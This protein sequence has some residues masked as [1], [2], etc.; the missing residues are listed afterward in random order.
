[1]SQPN[2]EFELKLSLSE[3][4]LD[5]VAGSAG[6]ANDGE[7]SQKVLRSVYYDSPDHRLHDNGIALR[8]RD[9]GRDYL[10]TV[11]AD[12]NPK[13]GILN[14]IEIEDRIENAEPKLHLI[15]NKRIR[16]K[17]RKA[18]ANS[19]LMPA[20]ETIV[21]R[22]TH[23]LS[24]RGSI[25]ELALDK[26]EAQAAGRKT[27]ICEAE[28]ELIAGDP[29]DL[30]EIAQSLFSKRAIHVSSIS[31]AERGYRLLLK[32]RKQGKIE[33]ARGGK[34]NVKAGQTCGKAFAEIFRSAREQ[35]IK[36][37]LVV[38]ETDEPEGAHQLRVGL[39]RLRSAHRVLRALTD[40]PLLQQLEHD[41]QALSRAVGRLRDADVLIQDIYAP[42]AGKNAPKR[43]GFN[44]LYL[45]L[46]G[47]RA[48][49]QEEARRALMSEHWS[50]LL[51]SLTLW[52][53]IL[54]RDEALNAPIEDYA[55]KALQNRWKKVAKLGRSL[56]SLSQ[57]D[58]H[59][60]RR[61][62]KKLRYMVEFFSPLYPKDEVRKFV[63]KLKNLQDIFGYMNDVRMGGQIRDIC[64]ERCG[65]EMDCF[66]AA[67]YV[68]GQHELKV[69]DV[70]AG[71]FERWRD[72]EA[73]ER[74]WA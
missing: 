16:R 51:L 5:C 61:S 39:T 19:T 1:M 2:R 31:K 45:A 66:V 18:V 20:F 55:S 58:Q 17:V 72:L 65:V 8:V 41:A 52:P 21:T 22:T 70:R 15:S 59:K 37:R 56:E 23:R 69:I 11:K 54:E 10:Q 62:L 36:N 57:A 32:T 47:H 74:F 12:A 9:N 28:L 34:P 43:P 68:L 27:P 42:V 46:L 30:L 60:M 35:I 4:E 40:S 71:A 7:R 6:L 63:K 64:N 44:Q 3:E 38:L 26:G 67:G 53:H 48:A 14:P 33:P 13:D 49:M 73:T 50:R 25:I 24:K 29:A